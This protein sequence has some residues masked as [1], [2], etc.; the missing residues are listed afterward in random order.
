MSVIAE[1]AAAKGLPMRWV[2]ID[3][4]ARAMAG[5]EENSAKD[6]GAA[7]AGMETISSALDCA[8]TVIHHSGKDTSRGERGSNSLRGAAEA[9]IEV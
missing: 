4:L 7:I 9:S 8:V 6:M 2:I 3:T 5:M 1:E